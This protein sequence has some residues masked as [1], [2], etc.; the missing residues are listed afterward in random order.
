MT[1]IKVGDLVKPKPQYLGLTGKVTA[2]VYCQGNR[3]LFINGAMLPAF[4]YRRQ[5][6]EE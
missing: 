6:A 1:D 4:K 2:V 3:W 5:V